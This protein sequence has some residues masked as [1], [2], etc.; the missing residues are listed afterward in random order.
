VNEHIVQTPVQTEVRST[1]EAIA[2]GA[3]AL[4]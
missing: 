3:M 2:A 1:Q 4:A